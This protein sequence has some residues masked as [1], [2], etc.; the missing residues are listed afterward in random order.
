VRRYHTA[1]EMLADIA[2]VASGRSVKKLRG[3]ERR[4]KVLR[5]S[6]LAA[7]AVA[8]VAL[9]ITWLVKGQADRE[10]SLRLRANQAELAALYDQVHA[11]RHDPARLPR[12]AVL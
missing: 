8:V 2:L 9:G 6:G 3:M 10:R 7:A 4:L 1:R 5:W 11:A 12:R